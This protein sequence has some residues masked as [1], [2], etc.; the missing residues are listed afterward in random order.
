MANNDIR[1]NVSADTREAESELKRL[2]EQFEKLQKLSGTPSGDAS[3]SVNSREIDEATKKFQSSYSS[4]VN[5]MQSGI[6][7]LKNAMN[8][9]DRQLEQS[10]LASDAKMSQSIQSQINALGTQRQQFEETL[11]QAD[12]FQRRQQQMA[13]SS[14]SNALGNH[15]N[16]GMGGIYSVGN[17]NGNNGGGGYTGPILDGMPSSFNPNRSAGGGFGG[18]NNG[19]DGG[20]GSTSSPSSNSGGNGISLSSLFGGYIGIRATRSIF[21]ALNSGYDLMDRDE[22]TAYNVTQKTGDYGSDFTQARKDMENIGKE[23]G[24]TMSEVAQAASTYETIGGVTNTKNSLQ[25]VQDI[26]KFSRAYAV[27]QNQVAAVSGNMNKIG[28]TSEGEQQKFASMLAQSIK[29][30]GMSGRESELVESTNQLAQSVASAKTTVNSTDLTGLMAMQNMFGSMSPQLRGSQGASVL[31]SMNSNIQNAD[32]GMQILLGRNSEFTG[33]EGMLQLRRQQEKGISDPQNLSRI[34]TNSEKLAGGNKSYQELILMDKL[35][36]SSSVADQLLSKDNYNDL[37]SGKKAQSEIDKI[38]SSNGDEDSK[39]AD[40]KNS[41]VNR[42]DTYKANKENSSKAVGDVEDSIVT[43]WQNTYDS[44]GIPGQIGMNAISGA[45]GIGTYSMVAKGLGKLFKGGLGNIFKGKGGASGEEFTSEAFDFAGDMGATAEGAGAATEGIGSILSKAGSVATKGAP[46]ISG[47]FSAVSAYSDAKAEGDTTGK[48]VS[49]GAGAGIGAGLG[50]WGGATAGATAGAA[51]GSIV[52]GL[53]TVIGGGIGAIGGAIIGGLGGSS[54]GSTLGSGIYDTVEGSQS[55]SSAHTGTNDIVNQR[56][57][58]QKEWKDILQSESD[59]VA[60]R[61]NLNKDTQKTGSA[62]ADG[63]SNF[64]SNANSINDQSASDNSGSQENESFF[65]KVLD[66]LGLGSKG[67]SSSSKSSANRSAVTGSYKTGTSKI[68]D[69]V[70]G[71]RGTVSKYAAQAGIG[72]QT[73]LLLAQI[74]QESG[75]DSNA[76]ANDPMQS[77]EGHGLAA[78][79]VLGQDKSIQYGTQEF[80]NRLKDAN[81]DTALALQSYN[82]GS[83]FIDYVNK[84]GGKMTQDLIN[85]FSKQQASKNG[86]SSYGDT[87]YVQNVLRY[88]NGSAAKYAIGSKSLAEDGLIYAHKGEK[89]IRADE[90]SDNPSNVSSTSNLLSTLTSSSNGSSVNL[91][92]LSLAINVNGAGFSAE[93]QKTVA[94]AAAQ[95]INSN[96]SALLNLLSN[97]MTREVR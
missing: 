29:E 86:W 66:W 38:T 6:D 91:G 77:A 85:S 8:E 2:E 97:G 60:R 34:L 14:N 11:R 39:Y 37:K 17:G 3:S 51:I 80:A 69:T 79:T 72:N 82:F 16:P 5:S 47:L 54:V 48:A 20:G 64:W 78:G 58:Q 4:L 62:S 87:N 71:L 10:Q 25:D 55:A 21:G 94:N 27:D 52:P 49:K 19:G 59:I 40:Y 83:G 45:M 1:L 31:G 56:L 74:M 44:M 15:S 63:T 7:N 65:D 92:T 22:R 13:D 32:N 23:T 46:I 88:Y 43:P 96:Q 84:N 28:A 57:D 36:I 18:G 9:Y 30:Q 24:R 41:D 95:V 61:E 12:E 76:L 70:E 68:S 33:P 53:G 67:G 93:N 90:N 35:G 81:G 73:D 50:A 89:I 42:R 26:E 75:G